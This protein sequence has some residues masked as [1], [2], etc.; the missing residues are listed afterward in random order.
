VKPQLTTVRKFTDSLAFMNLPIFDYIDRDDFAIVR[1]EELGMQLPYQTAVYRPDHFS[2]IIVLDGTA[3]YMIGDKTFELDKKHVLFTQ[4]STF[5]SSNWKTLSTAYNISFSKQF[6]MQFWPYG[7][8]DIQK[9]DHEKSY[10]VILS[11]DHIRYFE[12]ICL[13]IYR[14]ALACASYKY[15]II[16]NLVYNLLLLVRQQHIKEM[17]N[18]KQKYNVYVN[19]FMRDLEDNFISIAS[20][21][22]DTLLTLSDYAGR[23]NLNESYLAK[24]VSNTTGKSVN[25]WIDESRITEIKY[26]LK[27]TDKPIRDI[28]ILYGFDDVNYFYNYFKKHTQNA[29]GLFRE[30]FNAARIPAG[31]PVRI[32]SSFNNTISG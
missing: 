21:Q 28:A 14:E 7:I 19:T 2:L 26:L 29:P 5:F 9:F 16:T 6:L 18:P 31:S 13:E 4:P 23:Q 20:G 24:T 8:D 15:E 11:D 27:Y 32:K 1:M 25:Q 17:K 3:T 10:A 22:T 30:N 12:S